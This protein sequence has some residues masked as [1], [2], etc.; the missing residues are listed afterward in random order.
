[1]NNKS[2]RYHPA[3]ASILAVPDRG[4]STTR[5]KCFRAGSTT[6]DANDDLNIRMQV[7]KDHLNDALRRTIEKH[8]LPVITYLC[9]LN[10]DEQYTPRRNRCVA[11]RMKCYCFDFLSKERHHADVTKLILRTT[12]T[13]AVS[14]LPLLCKI[15]KGLQSPHPSQVHC[16]VL[17]SAMEQPLFSS[18]SPASPTGPSTSKGP[19]FLWPNGKAGQEGWLVPVDFR[20]SLKRGIETRKQEMGELEPGQ[21]LRS[22]ITK[23]MLSVAPRKQKLEVMQEANQNKQNSLF[24]KFS[25]FSC[26]FCNSESTAPYVLL[27]PS[28]TEDLAK[29]KAQRAAQR[30]AQWGRPRPRGPRTAHPR[31]RARVPRPRGQPQQTRGTRTAQPR[32]RG[33][34]P[35][36]PRPAPRP[37]PPPLSATVNTKIEQIPTN[38]QEC[39]ELEELP[40][41]LAEVPAFPIFRLQRGKGQCCPHPNRVPPNSTHRHACKDDKLPEICF[42]CSLIQEM[43]D[44]NTSLLTPTQWA[45]SFKIFE[46][47][48]ILR[49]LS[50]ASPVPT[51]H[52]GKET[53]GETKESENTTLNNIKRWKKEGSLQAH[54]LLNVVNIECYLNEEEFKQCFQMARATFLLQPPWWQDKWRKHVFDG[55]STGLLRQASRMRVYEEKIKK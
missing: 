35:R 17:K 2:S 27:F 32:P 45:A 46:L 21:H 38:N 9:C 14:V 51:Q 50:L 3:L 15:Q 11:E 1:M 22:G 4:S 40:L 52:H 33:P 23:A 41:P 10:T 7:C 44:E 12:Q 24:N 6:T 53:C 54:G 31:P 25:K 39:K 49:S 37:A 28:V 43:S 34:R 8:V 18:P 47:R 26:H 48:P 5:A 16:A 20:E 55:G 36:P 29:A 13:L 42:N 30:A 19:M